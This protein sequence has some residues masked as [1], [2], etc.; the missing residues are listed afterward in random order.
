MYSILMEQHARGPEWFIRAGKW[1]GKPSVA[2]PGNMSDHCQDYSR[3]NHVRGRERILYFPF[4]F[5][6][7]YILC[8]K[9]QNLWYFRK[10]SKFFIPPLIWKKFLLGF[11][12]FSIHIRI[13]LFHFSL[14]KVRTNSVLASTMISSS[15][16]QFLN[17]FRQKNGTLIL[18][19]LLGSC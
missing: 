5:C 11:S 15:L 17:E 12:F 3:I 7:Y 10:N 4:I 2:P 19:V 13:Y 8:F 16:I 14:K 6:C 18:F 9:S 1:S